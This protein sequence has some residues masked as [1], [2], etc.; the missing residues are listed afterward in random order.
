MSKS[1]IYTANTSSQS[2]A[3]NGI[4]NPGTV[5]RRFGPNLTLSG[6]AIQIAGAGYYDIDTSF[7]VAPTAA[8]EVTITA[9]LDNV[10]IPGASATGTVATADDYITLPVTAVFRQPCECWEGLSSLTFVLTG[11]AANVTNSAIVVE[12]K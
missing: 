8:G 10:A 3:L 12:K 2:V 11:T 1:L 6:N 4:I 5:V 7:T 9:Y